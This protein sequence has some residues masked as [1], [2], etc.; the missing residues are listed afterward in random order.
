MADSPKVLFV[1]NDFPPQEGGIQ[2]FIEGLIRQLPQ[3]SVVVHASSYSDPDE[4]ERYD[5][6]IFQEL[7][8]VVVRDRQ[9]ILLP[10]PGLLSRVKGT[11]H[12]HQITKVVFASSVPLG[13]LAPS[14]RRAGASTLIAITHGHEVWWARM[15]IFAQILRYVARHCDRITYLGQFT[16]SAISKAIAPVDRS[17]LVHLPPGVDIERFHPGIKSVEQIE[18]YGLRGKSVVLSVGRLV[19]R[20]G[21]D[22]LIRA[23]PEIIQRVPHAHLLIVGAGNYENALKNLVRE[24]ELDAFVTFAGRIPLKDL[25]ALFQS[26]EL[27]VSPTRD[28][29]AGL[30]VEGLGIVYLEASASGLA[31]IAGASGGSPDALLHNETGVVVNGRD[32]SAVATAVTDLLSDDALRSRMGTA[33]REWMERQ[34]S[35]DVIG[36]RFRSLLE[37]D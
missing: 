9:R 26:A 21:H 1:T 31:V 20:K 11:I 30:E 32:V 7:G 23:L 35:W 6:R 15:P 37:L 3:S 16:K 28:R 17:K 24:L 36:A 19:Q 25:P 22:V 5:Q 10:T 14:L 29:F 33:G 34:W 4:A 27:F 8:V 13:M 2:T 12:A 18:R